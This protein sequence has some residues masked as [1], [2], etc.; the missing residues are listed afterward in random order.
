[1]SVQAHHSNAEIEIDKIIIG[2]FAFVVFV[3]IA[4]TGVPE[5]TAPA[6]GIH[7]LEVGN[8]IKMIQ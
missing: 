6:E 2:L 3:L 8:L 5:L 4:L 7:T 1:M